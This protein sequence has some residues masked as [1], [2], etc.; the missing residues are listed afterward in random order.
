MGTAAGV[1]AAVAS[2]AAAAAGR[3]RSDSSSSSWW[4]GGYSIVCARSIERRRLGSSPSSPSSP[5]PPP[6]RM[7]PPIVDGRRSPL[8]RTAMLAPLPEALVPAPVAAPPP[9]E[10]PAGR[11]LTPCAAQGECSRH[12]RSL[13]ET[14]SAHV[15]VHDTLR[16]EERRKQGIVRGARRE[17]RA[18]ARD[19]VIV[20]ADRGGRDVA[21]AFWEKRDR[22]EVRLPPGRRAGCVEK[23]A[24]RSAQGGHGRGTCQTRRLAIRELHTCVW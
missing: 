15:H 18:R 13:E 19:Q 11:H 22:D 1:K 4:V 21:V 2:E 8:S 10:P 14:R 23:R 16:G 3:S 17:D 6:S 9:L 12:W 7:I 24:K 20:V 5:L